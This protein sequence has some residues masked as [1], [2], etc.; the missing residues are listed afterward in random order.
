MGRNNLAYKTIASD[1]NHSQN[2]T[3]IIT[4]KYLAI[5][6]KIHESNIEQSKSESSSNREISRAI[7]NVESIVDSW[8]EYFYEQLKTFNI[9]REAFPNVLLVSE[10]NVV[11]PQTEKKPA[12]PKEENIIDI[13]NELEKDNDSETLDNLAQDDEIDPTVCKA[14]GKAN[15]MVENTALACVICSECGMVNENVLDYGPEWRSYATDEHGTET[16]GRCGCPTNYYF[17]QST[18]GTIIVGL[19][20]A[21]LI[22][23]QKW[24]SGSYKE[25]SL[26]NVFESISE[27]CAKSGIKKIIVDTAKLMYKVLSECKHKTGKNKGKQVIIRGNNRRGIIAVCVLKA[28]ELNKT[29]KNPKEIANIFRLTEK[30]IT[31]AKRLYYRILK[32][33]DNIP[34][35]NNNTS[36]ED[37]IKSHCVKLKISP[38]YTEIAARI[39][40]NCY[41]MK[42]ASD[43]NMA[44]VAAGI[45]GLMVDY[46]N[47]D[48]DRKDIAELFG[49]SEVTIMKIYNKI[50]AYADALVDDAITDHLIE[51]FEM[52]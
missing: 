52:N 5:Y 22:R 14:C 31:R 24:N 19:N 44:S 21:R 40:K 10:H 27:I 32:N 17:P 37:Y 16:I 12:Q 26:N 23:K 51:K 41:K 1:I 8:I 18:Q 30:D 15:V 43:H 11:A 6:N 29:P 42:L 7:A 34:W 49:T 45:I 38:E 47:L 46:Y 13:I 33:C 50:E 9:R 36:P 48:I 3:N 4:Y 28:C 39:S 25:K 35:Q 2:Y 20:N